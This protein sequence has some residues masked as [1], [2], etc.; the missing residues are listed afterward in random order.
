MARFIVERRLTTPDQ[1]L[2]F[3]TGGYTYA[4]DLSGPGK[5]AFFRTEAAAAAA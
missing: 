3:D 1:I 2:D 5:P 4:P